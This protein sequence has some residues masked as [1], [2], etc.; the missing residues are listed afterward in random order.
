MERTSTKEKL[1]LSGVLV[2]CVL[3]LRPLLH[4]VFWCPVNA[5][6]FKL[7]FAR[8]EQ[9]EGAEPQF[10]L[11]SILQWYE[12]WQRPQHFT[13]HLST[14]FKVC[15]LSPVP[16]HHIVGQ[17]RL[18]LGRRM[19]RIS[20]NLAV[21][22]PLLLPGENKISLIRAINR[23]LW[24]SYVREAAMTL[25]MP[26]PVFWLNFPFNE[27]LVKAIPFRS[28][29]YDVMDEFVEFS[30]APRNAAA[31]EA[32]V[33]EAASFVSTGTYALFQKKKALHAN[34]EYIPCG[35]D[36]E[37]FNGVVM[38]RPPAPSDFPKVQGAT[39]GYF[40]S[41]NE[42]IDG[43]MIED[44]ARRR[45]SW[46]F[47]MIGPVHRSYSADRQ[48]RNVHYLGL[49]GYRSLPAYLAYFDVCMMPYKITEATSHISP[50]KLLEY[51]ASGKPVITTRIPDVL[52]FYES[53]V[54]VVDDANDFITKAEAILRTKSGGQFNPAPFIEVARRRS[55]AEMSEQMLEGILGVLK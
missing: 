26:K 33:L 44:V 34:V 51:F 20:D 39:F 11:A 43:K 8:R 28:V 12:V 45:P 30:M 38:R 47:V 13:S 37:L 52:R 9:E 50:V 42:R 40:G 27:R 17:A 7:F 48:L 23:L 18:W 41:L 24:V 6:R 54:W 46:T 21:F 2:T 55:W 5:V 15:F 14:K 3:S 31:R 16:V 1:S 49:K 35:V 36:F 53:L 25:R 10:L 22:A 32:K 19:K 4:F 29:V